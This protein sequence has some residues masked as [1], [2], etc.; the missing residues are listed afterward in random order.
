MFA[1]RPE[2]IALKVYEISHC[3]EAYAV[4]GPGYKNLP[5]S[6]SIDIENHHGIQAQL[7]FYFTGSGGFPGSKWS[8][9]LCENQYAAPYWLSTRVSFR[10]GGVDVLGSN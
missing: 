5:A 9:H 10:R 4:C 7:C 8:D 1:T 6:W 2:T 3:D